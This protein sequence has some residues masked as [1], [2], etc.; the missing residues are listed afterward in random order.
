M[1]IFR[2]SP[3]AEADLTGIARYA[4]RQWGEE[5]AIRYL[6]ALEG[7]CAELAQSLSSGRPCSSIRPGLWR[8]EQGSHVV[9]FGRATEGIHVSRILHQRILPEIHEMDDDE[10][11]PAP[12]STR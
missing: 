10:P 5:Q 2:F 11:E 8:A 9:F 3:R 12:L 7:R 6:D 4:S 1:G